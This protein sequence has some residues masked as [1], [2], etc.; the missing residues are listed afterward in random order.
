MTCVVTY[1]QKC[2]GTLLSDCSISVLHH[3]VTVVDCC[4]QTEA[5]SS[6]D[7]ADEASM[8]IVELVVIHDGVTD[9]PSAGEHMKHCID[10]ERCRIPVE[11]G[12]SLKP[13]PRSMTV[14]HKFAAS[15]TT[16]AYPSSEPVLLG[17]DHS[18]AK[19]CV[20]W[21]PRW[22]LHFSSTCSLADKTEM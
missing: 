20:R 3:H 2:S 17:N 8:V 9:L 4:C 1:G 14:K 18:F 5:Q 21:R 22:P 6:D 10:N 19:F 7:E 16:T 11:G 12:G 13:A 15:S